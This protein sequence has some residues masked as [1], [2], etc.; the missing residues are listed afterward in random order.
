MFTLDKPICLNISSLIFENPE[1]PP[2]DI[3]AARFLGSG[4][5]YSAEVHLFKYSMQRMGSSGERDCGRHRLI[6][7]PSVYT[8][9]L[10]VCMSMNDMYLN[11]HL[12][13]L[14]SSFY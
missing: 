1:N 5:E 2:Q 4:G 9:Q 8:V 6:C 10:T 11:M 7:F 14:F 13:L 12:C 3:L